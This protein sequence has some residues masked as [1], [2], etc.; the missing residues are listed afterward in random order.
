MT[1]TDQPVDERREKVT[2]FVRSEI[3]PS[4]E[5]GGELLPVL[6][7]VGLVKLLMFIES[8][9][10][11]VVDVSTLDFDALANVDTLL[12]AIS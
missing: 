11:V 1:Q 5:A 2:A 4:F 8:D 10:G 7:S 12:A 6:D 9:L 3:D